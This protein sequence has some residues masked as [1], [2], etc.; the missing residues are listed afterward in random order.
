MVLTFQEED[1]QYEEDI[2]R[3]SF[4]IKAWLRYIDHK[5]GASPMARFLIYERALKE[6]PGR[7]VLPVCD[8]YYCTLIIHF[9]YTLW[10]RYLN[11]RVKAVARL[12]PIDPSRKEVNHV[13][14]RA[15]VFMHKVI[16]QYFLSHT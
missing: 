15:L 5:R 8:L 3:N 11:E 2:L 16:P 6:L 4:S 14:E 12:S 13:F 7:C 10:Y 1:V 9:S